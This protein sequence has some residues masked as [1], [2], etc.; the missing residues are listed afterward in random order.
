MACSK[1]AEEEARLDFLNATL[2]EQIVGTWVQGGMS[3]DLDNAITVWTDS[4]RFNS[5]NTGSQSVY[6]FKDLY[7]HLSFNYYTERDSLFIFVKGKRH[8]SWHYEIRNDSLMLSFQQ[9]PA[10]SY[11]GLKIYKRK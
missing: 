10:S 9:S 11:Y 5:D 8:A 4:I 6:Q 7:S 1:D 2:D 3:K